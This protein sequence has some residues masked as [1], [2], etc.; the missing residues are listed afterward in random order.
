MPGPFELATKIAVKE[1]IENH[2]TKSK[3]GAFLSD[4]ATDDLVAEIYDLIVM[5]RNLKSTGDKLLSGGLNVNESKS[6]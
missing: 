2:T 5:S 4:E 3:F 6:R 1:I